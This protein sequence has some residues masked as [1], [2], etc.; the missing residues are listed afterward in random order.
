MFIKSAFHY[1][2]GTSWTN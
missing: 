1:R 2:N